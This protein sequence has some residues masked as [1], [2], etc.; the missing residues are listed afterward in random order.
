MQV[1]HLRYTR[2]D[3]E[4]EVYHLKDRHSYAVGR[5][6]QCH[7]RIL[8]MKMSRQ[9]FSLEYRNDGWHL[10]DAGSTNGVVVNGHRVEKDA[11]L[12]QGD[13]IRAGFSELEVR[14]INGSLD[15]DEDELM[16]EMDGLATIS[17]PVTKEKDKGPKL[18]ETR[19]LMDKGVNAISGSMV[20]VMICGKKIGPINKTLARELKAKELKG[21]LTDDDLASLPRS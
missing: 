6:S 9:H 2:P 17:D 11:L 12:R 21:L 15:L 5:G 1:M 13:R 20:Y 14:R 8:D 4:T 3:G 19:I 18:V 16:E 10:V 7:L